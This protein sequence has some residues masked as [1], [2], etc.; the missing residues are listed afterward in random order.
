MFGS[1]DDGALKREV[2]GWKD[3]RLFA[4]AGQ[5]YSVR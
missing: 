3:D 4:E 5:V 1:H 2:E